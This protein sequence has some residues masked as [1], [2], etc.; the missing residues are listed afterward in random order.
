MLCGLYFIIKDCMSRASAGAHTSHLPPSVF[1][2]ILLLLLLHPPQFFLARTQNSGWKHKEKSR[3]EKRQSKPQMFSA[4]VSVTQHELDY[5]LKNAVNSTWSCAPSLHIRVIALTDW[6]SARCAV[7]M[8]CGGN[9][10]QH[11]TADKMRV[12]CQIYV[13]YQEHLACDFLARFI[14]SSSTS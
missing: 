7:G 6:S 10:A 8:V 14:T 2:C 5:Y 12:Q 9:G 13:I 3:G 11:S 1:D 4:D